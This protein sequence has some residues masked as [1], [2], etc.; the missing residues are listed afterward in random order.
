MRLVHDHGEALAGKLADLLSDH[1]ELLERGHDDC[2]ARLEGLLELARGG[3]DVLDHA[4]R[5]LELAH[6]GLELPVENAPVGDHHDRVE[7]PPVGR[8]ME[9]GK[10]VGEPGDREALP[11]PRRVLDQV[12]LACPVRACVAHQPADGVELLVAGEDEEPIAGLAA[13]LVFLLDLVNELA[14]EVEHAVAGPGLLPQVGGSITIPGGRY[15]RVPGSAELPLV[16]RQEA[17]LRSHQVGR[18]VDQ[19]RVHREVREA[20]PVGEERLPRVAV[21]L[22]LPNRILDILSGQRVL[23]LGRE[24]R[25]AVKDEHKVEALVV[26]LAVMKLAH[27]GEEVRRVQTSGLLV[28]PARGPVVR[29]PELAARVLDAL[30]QHVERA[31]PLDLAGEALQELLRYRRAVVLLEPFPL[32]RLRGEDEVH[33]V[34]RDEAERAVVVRG[35]ALAVTARQGVAIGQ[36]RLADNSR[37]SGTGIGAVLEQPALDGLLEAALGDLWTQL[38]SLR[39]TVVPSL[40]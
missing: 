5:L 17:R 22:V 36:R 6:G 1:R 19:V 27:N 14:D 23:Q 15:R 20:A 34:A 35:R 7:H 39:T 30:A 11:A 38:F 21:G 31:A 18:D 26:L 3:I 13:L 9:R 37:V 28:E 2:L 24:D 16:E 10:L 12:A 4:E 8:V 32:L 25:D 40:H 29:H 33:H